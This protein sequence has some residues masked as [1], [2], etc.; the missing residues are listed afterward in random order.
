MVNNSL[1]VVDKLENNRV[2]YN[3][4]VVVISLTILGLIFLYSISKMS[5]AQDI[6]TTLSTLTTIVGTIIGAFLGVHIGAAGKADAIEARNQAVEAQQKAQETA[7]KFA[8]A[9]SLDELPDELKNQIFM[10]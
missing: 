8:A 6:T 7:N 5:N 2:M 4:I 3:A 10:P 1:G 9:T